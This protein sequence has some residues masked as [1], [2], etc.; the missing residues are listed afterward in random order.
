MHDT[1]D[2]KILASWF[3]CE[4]TLAIAS[5]DDIRNADKYNCRVQPLFI[6]NILQL[7]DISGKKADDSTT[8]AIFGVTAYYD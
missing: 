2:F 1:M 6:V 5:L 3:K 4:F 8:G 7:S